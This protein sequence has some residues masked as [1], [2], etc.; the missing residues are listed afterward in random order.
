MPRYSSE[1]RRRAVAA[2]V[3]GRSQRSVAAELGI[4]R[5]TLAGWVRQAGV[6]QQ[7]TPV[8]S[9]LEQHESTPAGD[10]ASE[11]AVADDDA[12]PLA[13]RSEPD[14]ETA[15]IP[16]V[17][18]PAP[19]RTAGPV[20]RRRS[21]VLVGAAAVTVLAVV[22]A[23]VAMRT[24]ELVGSAAA[25]DDL[26]IAVD[27]AYDR[28][29]FDTCAETVEVVG[30]LS[31]FDRA[32]TASLTH[33]AI[34]AS[35]DDAFARQARRDVSDARDS[36]ANVLIANVPTSEQREVQA[37]FGTSD[38][39]MADC[40]AATAPRS[41]V[42]V[43]DPS[44]DDVD[45]LRELLGTI[46]D[47]GVAGANLA[48]IRA[49]IEDLTPIVSSATDARLA[50]AAGADADV[51][52]TDL[53][54]AESALLDGVADMD[55]R[56]TPSAVLD[57]TSLL[58]DYAFVGESLVGDTIVTDGVE[59]AAMPSVETP[60][61]TPEPEIAGAVAEIPDT[62]GPPPPG[63][64]PD[65][66]P[67]VRPTYPGSGSTPGAT[68]SPTRPAGS[69]PTPS[70]TGGSTDPGT[71][72]PGTTDPGTTDPGTTDPGTTDPGTTDPGTTDPDPTDPGTTDPEPTEPDP[73]DPGTTDPDPTDPGTTDP[74][75]TDPDPTD[76]ETDEPPAVD[77]P[78]EDPPPTDGD[79]DEP[80]CIIDLLG[81]EICL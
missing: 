41:V 70:P 66:L 37:T 67:I 76:P 17:A 81:I 52:E 1:L 4:A 18:A 50:P 16:V 23:S 44:S 42:P 59:I 31:L 19:V 39:V 6:T 73:T 5:A 77:P 55:N 63:P 8:A 61:V 20:P 30:T 54:Q 34:V 26:V 3:R 68:A 60:L 25:Y 22:V 69:T 49:G 21:V 15:E 45:E 62:I 36:L 32:A 9:F 56:A 79:E 46:E 14:A 80:V 48:A 12:A 71:T 64:Q 11:T 51:T 35:A 78:D 74:D 2:V 10:A 47:D 57:A 24:R 28:A 40:L 27:D 38:D 75:P 13:R 33:L 43:D 65:P 58:A 7:P 72:D 29:R 53:D